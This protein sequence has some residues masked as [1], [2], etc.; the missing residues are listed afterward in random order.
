MQIEF[1]PYDLN[2]RHDWTV[3]NGKGKPRIAE[4]I[5]IRLTSD[6]ISG[7]GEATPSLRYG[8]S[9]AQALEFLRQI[10]PHVLSFDDL[11]GS[12]LRLEELAPMQHAAK[13]AL[14]MA[15]IDGAG[16]RRQT[17]VYDFLGLGF[18]EGRHFTSF[19]I[20]L[21][22][23][24]QIYT[25]VLE[26]ASFPILKLKLG[27]IYDRENLAA[28]RRAA[29]H[30]IVRVD[31]NEAW[32]TRDEALRK[33]EWLAT[34]P[35]IQFV[36]QP[37]PASLPIEDFIWLK[38]RSPL[39]IYAD[40]SCH[41]IR[42]VEVCAAGFNGVNVKLTKAGGVIAGMKLLRA[43]RAARLKT[44]IG[45][46]V[47]S[48]LATSAAAHLAALADDLDI[49]GNLLIDNDPCRGVGS[50]GGRIS[51]VSAPEPF[52]LRV[53]GWPGAGGSL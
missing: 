45:C 32:P 27:S 4:V 48:S 15:L 21:A 30:K 5:F 33:I 44:M 18:S 50:M 17:P 22:Q 35:H 47:E 13:A 39:P 43:A 51:F 10:D 7:L 26:A 1:R 42:D 46:M 25:K 41:S 24:D 16:R 28:L 8:E 19:T 12:M 20:G 29:P 49:D 14:N 53:C 38:E 11:D 23:P 9:R 36:E 34:D 52:G 3:A 37:M 6:G 31:A 2:L 40:E